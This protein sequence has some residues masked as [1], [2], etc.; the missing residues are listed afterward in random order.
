M[1]LELKGKMGVE[2][3]IT[4]SSSTASRSIKAEDPLQLALAQLDYRKS[5][6]DAVR[7]SSDVPNMGAASLED[8][9][10]AALQFLAKSQ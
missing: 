6:I 4:G 3:H 1:C 2:L 10:R 5:E 7:Y 9:L 8:R